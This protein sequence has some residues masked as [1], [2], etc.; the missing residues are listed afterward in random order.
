MCVLDTTAVEELLLALAKFNDEA[1]VSNILDEL[2]AGP[3]LLTKVVRNFLACQNLDAALFYL[4]KVLSDSSSRE[5]PPY[6]LIQDVIK[7]S[8][9]AEM[10]DD[11]STS[12]ARAKAWDALDVLQDVVLNADSA[13]LFLEW[14]A[15]Q[16]PVDVKMAMSI[17]KLLRKA[18]PVPVDAFDAL[19]RVHAS[20]AGDADKAMDLF[21]EL[22]RVT[23]ADGPAEASLVGMISSCI[24]ARNSELAE[25]ILNWACEEDKCT[26]PVFSATLKVLATST[27]TWY[28]LGAFWAVPEMMSGVLASSMRME[29]TSSTMPKLNGSFARRVRSCCVGHIWS[30]R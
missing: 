16:T 2:T 19:V 17:E 8:T 21:D 23:K 7:V 10:S 6:E 4:E 27:A 11:F 20:S 14:S 18:G 13:L 3:Q 9:E 30:R 28:L 22:V 5:S 25:H 12:S 26:L 29:S 15:R 24:E 1:R